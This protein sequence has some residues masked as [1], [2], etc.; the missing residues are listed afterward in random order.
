MKTR[1]KALHDYSMQA[2]RIEPDSPTVIFWLV[3]ALRK[4]GAIDMAKKHLESAKTRLFEEEYQE[5]ECRL[6]L[7]V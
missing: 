7:P 6:R 4:N 1:N 2:I 5:L 3:V